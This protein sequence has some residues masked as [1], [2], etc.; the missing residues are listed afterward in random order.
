MEARSDAREG[1]AWESEGGAE[2]RRT[3]S[4]AWEGERRAY[5]EGSSVL[6]GLVEELY[7]RGDGG[8]GSFVRAIACYAASS[9]PAV[10]EERRPPVGCQRALYDV[11]G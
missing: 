2:W 7:G 5:N 10:Q 4:A 3:R 9:G 8:G 11:D 6:K 1:D